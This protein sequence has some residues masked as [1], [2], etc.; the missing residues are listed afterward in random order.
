MGL[1]KSALDWKTTIGAFVALLSQILPLVG[2]ELS[3]EVQSALITLGVFI[4]GLFAKQ[5]E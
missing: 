4:V 5:V 2:I 1:K 3:A